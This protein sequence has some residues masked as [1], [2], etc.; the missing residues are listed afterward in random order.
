[1]TEISKKGLRNKNNRII[2]FILFGIAIGLFS[3]GFGRGYT[4][5]LSEIFGNVYNNCEKK[6][7]DSQLLSRACYTAFSDLT[8]RDPDDN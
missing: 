6:Y 5:A 8:K 1:M 4:S 3:S 2:G 7:P